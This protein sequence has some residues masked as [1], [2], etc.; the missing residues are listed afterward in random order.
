LFQPQPPGPTPPKKGGGCGRTCGCGCLILILLLIVIIGGGYFALKS[1]TLKLTQ[2]LNI[3][4]LGPAQLEVDNF[5]D[6]AIKVSIKQLDVAKDSSYPSVLDVKAFEIRLYKIPSRGRYHVSFGSAAGGTDLGTCTLGVRG[7]DQYQ[8]VALPN[9]I[10]VNYKN[11]PSS[12]GSDFVIATSS[13]C[14]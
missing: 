9:R 4:G 11:Q 7:G 12:A 1:G 6:D 3:V 8:F 5:R 10:V 13:L 2:V 14:R